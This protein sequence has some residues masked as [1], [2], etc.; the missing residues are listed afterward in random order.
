MK[1]HIINKIPHKVD[2]PC[3]KIPHLHLR[4]DMIRPKIQF[5]QNFLYGQIP[6]E[7]TLAKTPLNNKNSEAYKAG[8]TDSPVCISKL[9]QHC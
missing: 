9:T 8:V 4:P 7:Y 3:V 5:R 2:H 1:F 6:N